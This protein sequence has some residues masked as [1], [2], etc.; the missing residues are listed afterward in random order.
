M[1]TSENYTS[2][3]SIYICMSLYRSV[4]HLAMYL[5]EMK[6]YDFEKY[7]VHIRNIC[8]KQNT[9]TVQRHPSKWIV[10]QLK[11]YS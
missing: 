7:V 2:Q 3:L 11:V 8:N 1:D 4:Y 6:T 10:E 5:R 9:G